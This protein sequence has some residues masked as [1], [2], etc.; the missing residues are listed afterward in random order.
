MKACAEREY[1][2][3]FGPVTNKMRQYELDSK[4]MSYSRCV[5]TA[6]R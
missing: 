6:L 5:G 1:S 4:V 2:K 3:L